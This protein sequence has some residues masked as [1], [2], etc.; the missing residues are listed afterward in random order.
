M[1]F[2]KR[3][4]VWLKRE[5]RRWFKHAANVIYCRRWFRNARPVTFIVLPR[6]YVRIAFFSPFQKL[7]KNTR[8]GR[9]DWR[10]EGRKRNRRPSQSWKKPFAPTSL[11]RG[12]R[13]ERDHKI[14]PQ[15]K[16]L[17]YVRRRDGQRVIVM[18]ERRG[19]ET[20]RTW[21]TRIDLRY[22]M[23]INALRIWPTSFVE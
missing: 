9:E 23:L 14:Y 11:W 1:L 5:F 22:A 4:S 10:T 20:G 15:E 12:C 21:K 16:R 17:A 19:C 3:Y 8:P 18:R 2:Y 6:V 7:K 13:D